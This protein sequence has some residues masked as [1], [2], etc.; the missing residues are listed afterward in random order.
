MPLS[1]RIVDEIFGRLLVR[2]GAAWIRMWEGIDIGPVKADW[3]QQLDGASVDS[4]RYGLDNLPEKYPPTVAE[5]RAICRGVPLQHVRML[6][7]PPINRT[8]AKE[9]AEKMRGLFKPKED[10]L[11]WAKELRR[12]EKAGESLTFFER[13]CWREALKNEGLSGPVLFGSISVIPK[14][15]LPPGMRGG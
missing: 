7:P 9:A 12:R 2:Y 3:A 1:Q 8:K 14:D 4:I 11:G 13:D 10:P 15:V 5:F 6:P